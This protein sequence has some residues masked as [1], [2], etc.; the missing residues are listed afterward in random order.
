MVTSWYYLLSRGI[1]QELGVVLISP[2]RPIILSPIE[3]FD[4]T[5]MNLGTIP[6]ININ[7]IYL[8]GGNSREELVLAA[9]DPSTIRNF[10]A[11]REAKAKKKLLEQFTEQDMQ[12]TID[13]LKRIRGS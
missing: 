12:R 8:F 9:K 13:F 5:N 10:V 11:T 3:Y 7:T 4:K 6:E 1:P 2:E